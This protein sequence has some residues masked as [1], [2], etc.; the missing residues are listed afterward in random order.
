ME[1]QNCGGDG[2]VQLRRGQTECP[3]CDGTGHVCAWCDEPLGSC[4]CDYDY[5]YYDDDD[6]DDDD[7]CPDCGRFDCNCGWL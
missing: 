1:C 7:V 3:D 6:D 4:V 5:D 2:V